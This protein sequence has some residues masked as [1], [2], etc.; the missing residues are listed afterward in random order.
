MFDSNHSN[1][2]KGSISS[3]NILLSLRRIYSNL[4]ACPADEIKQAHKNKQPVRQPAA[5]C[6]ALPSHGQN[7][8]T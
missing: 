8:A 2:H 7:E 6:L 4:S 1:N 5:A 3:A